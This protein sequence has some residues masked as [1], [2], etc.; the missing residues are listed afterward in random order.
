[1]GAFCPGRAAGVPA[2]TAVC[3]H[4]TRMARTKK[5]QSGWDCNRGMVVFSFVAGIRS[6]RY[7]RPFCLSN[8]NV[9][10]VSHQEW[11][12][13]M[14]VNFF[15]PHGHCRDQVGSFF[16]PLFAHGS[17]AAWHERVS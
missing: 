11:G 16:A 12:N 3:R 17:W 10:A 7:A 13:F 5:M 4:G 1:M 14:P 9:L 2:M 8:I 6:K 15:A